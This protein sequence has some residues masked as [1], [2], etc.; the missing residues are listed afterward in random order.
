MSKQGS[1]HYDL[2]FKKDVV[3]LSF[4]SGKTI[5]QLS[6]DMGISEKN[7]YRWR[8]E[9][10]DNGTVK[11]EQSVMEQSEE[12]KRLRS[13]LRETKEERDILKKAMAIFTVK[14]K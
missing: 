7:V 14:K 12:L 4:E 11:I 5:V 2:E 1:K 13:E 6:K 9:L 8:K 3:R 10:I